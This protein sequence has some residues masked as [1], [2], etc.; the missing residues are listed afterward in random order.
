[1]LSQYGQKIKNLKEE[2]SEAN[3]TI[4]KDMKNLDIF[5]EKY[6]WAAQELELNNETISE[7]KQ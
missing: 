6:N 2:L 7:L 1:M 4:S 3:A 5:D